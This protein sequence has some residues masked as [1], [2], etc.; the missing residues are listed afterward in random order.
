MADKNL[1][2]SKKAE[3]RRRRV[4]GKVVG[5]AQRPRM[6][7]A[8]SLNNTFVQIIDDEKG[9]T[10]VGLATNSKSVAAELKKDDTKTTAAKLVGKKIAAMAKENGIS[11]VVF[12]RNQ[13][14]YHGRVK[15]A[16]EGAREGGLKL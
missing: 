3:R 2:R 12:D 11:E 10:L 1:V 13:Y 6:T 16:A 9:I 14:K 5:T 4:R 7:V 8:K 15:A